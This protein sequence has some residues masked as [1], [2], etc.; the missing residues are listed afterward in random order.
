MRTFVIAWV[1]VLSAVG[2]VARADLDKGAWAPDI[3]AK[4]WKNVDEPVTLY[5]C[6]GMVVVL[7]FWVSWWEHGAEYVLPMMNLMNSEFGRSQ[8]VFMV[9]LTDA[10][11]S[12]VE[13]LLDEQ[14]V[15][16]PVGTESKSY[17]DY[18]IDSFPRVVVID[19]E[20]KVAWT[21]WPGDVGG[22]I[23][24]VR[25][26]ISDTPPTKTHPL[27]AAEALSDLEQAKT[28]I[29]AED[30][31]K[32]FREAESAYGHALT[33]DPLKLRCQAMVDLVEALARD[34]LAE[35]EWAVEDSDFETGVTLLRDVMRSFRG[36]DVALSAGRRLRALKKKY[37]PVQQLL[38]DWE[39]ETMAENALH[40]ALES[41]R[42]KKF[43]EAYDQMQAILDDYGSTPAADKVNVILERMQKNE[44]LM[45]YIGD[46]ESAPT[47]RSLLSQARAYL[48]TGRADR[49]REILHQIIRDYPKTI[50]ADDARQMLL[51]MR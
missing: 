47:C 51:D 1:C 13:K 21:G 31:R 16:F 42:A 32:A 25:K 9:G 43:G 4:Q 49:T 44:A 34:K 28:A 3:E 14:H 10:E 23:T 29:R 8:G 26:V 22:L 24:E 40:N 50:W 2:S 20:G 46:H 38:Q 12:R 27:E 39:N 45:A 11:L 6:K 18:D 37:P 36:T 30:Y 33:G 7:F 48:R 17:E 19:P 15:L 5:E 41:F 35:A